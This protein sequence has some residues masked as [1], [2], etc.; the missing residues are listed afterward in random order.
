MSYTGEHATSTLN[1]CRSMREKYYELL[2][3][4]DICTERR[5]DGR[6]RPNF[7]VQPQ[8]EKDTYE[9]FNDYNNGGNL[10]KIAKR[11][12]VASN[13]LRRRFFTRGLK[14]NK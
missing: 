7:A 10:E 5:P 12:G 1:F 9:A 11:Y 14:K 6:G 4:G 13:T 3:T 8:I 2:K